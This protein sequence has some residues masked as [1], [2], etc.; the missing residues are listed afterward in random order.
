MSEYHNVQ[1]SGLA[2]LL[3]VA[4]ALSGCLA[5]GD[6]GSGTACGP[7]DTKITNAVNGETDPSSASFEKVT[8]VGEVTQTNDATF[9][10]D[11]GSGKAL[12]SS[13][14]NP[15]EGDCVE[16]TGVPR[17]GGQITQ[18]RGADILIGPTNI[19]EM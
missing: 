8:V 3:V 6:G 17:S 4:M 12:I 9:V 13:R 2:V 14:N 19:S 1:T 11:D 16:I 15:S 10:V 7:G 5:L 18:D